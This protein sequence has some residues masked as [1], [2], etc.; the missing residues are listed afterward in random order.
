[1]ILLFVLIMLSRSRV[2]LFSIMSKYLPPVPPAPDAAPSATMHVPKSRTHLLSKT[3]AVLAQRRRLARL[4]LQPIRP[5]PPAATQVVM[6]GF[7]SPPDAASLS[8]A[9]IGIPNAGKSTLTNRLVASEVRGNDNSTLDSH[10]LHSLQGEHCHCQGTDDAA[11]HVGHHHHWQHATGIGSDWLFTPRRVTSSSSSFLQ[12][13]FDTPGT[14]SLR[15]QSKRRK[16]CAV[17]SSHVH[18]WA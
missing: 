5:A 17:L 13:F 14:V 9:L 3:D 10:S 11:A 18:A 12:A 8:V 2:A 1:L 7:R 16:R 6:Q 4:D 15:Q